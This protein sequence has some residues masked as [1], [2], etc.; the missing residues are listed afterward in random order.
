M[1]GCVPVDTKY[2][3]T[4]GSLCFLADL[5]LVRPFEAL[6]CSRSVLSVSPSTNLVAFQYNAA[7][8]RRDL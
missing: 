1:L 6:V 4:V 7:A 3:S 2:L 8:G 5:A